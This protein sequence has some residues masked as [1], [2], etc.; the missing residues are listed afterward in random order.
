L[1][2][3][4]GTTPTQPGQPAEGTHSDVAGDQSEISAGP[5]ADWPTCDS[6]LSNKVLAIRTDDC[7]PPNPGKSTRARSSLLC[8]AWPY[9]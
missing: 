8:R 1:C 6:P 9:G 2:K 5:E 3:Q 7:I 4:P